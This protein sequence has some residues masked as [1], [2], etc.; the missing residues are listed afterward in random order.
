M[1]HVTHVISTP[2]G[3]GG[4]E[5]VVGA[6]VAA[7][8][9]QGWNQTVLNPFA[10]HPENSSLT[11]ICSGARCAAARCG[12]PRDLPTLARWLRNQLRSSEP[13]LVHSHLFHAE[14]LVALVRPRGLPTVL[15]HHHGD[16]LAVEGRRAAEMIDRVAV[17]RYDRV[18]AISDWV[19]RFLRTRYRCPPERLV[20]IPNGWVNAASNGPSIRR[21]GGES[22]LILCVA[23][24]RPEKGHSEL[25]RA[26]AQVRSEVPYA[27]LQLVGSGPLEVEARAMVA[28]IGLTGCVDFV[29]PTDDVPRYLAAADVF[30]W[31]PATRRRESPWSRQWLLGCRPWP[32]R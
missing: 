6:L 12:S 7:G 8:A 26:F 15:T 19:A 2:S 3:I 5:Q 28:R 11:E 1:P 25:I 18:V 13:D 14:A 16:H 21:S 29:G 9:E 32:P 30:V 4:A 24:F 23:N 17:R 20:T 27:R 10:E 31:P 22:A